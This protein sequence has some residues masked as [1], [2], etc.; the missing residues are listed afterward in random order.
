[1]YKKGISWLEHKDQIT[2]TICEGEAIEPITFKFS[3]GAVSASPVNIPPGLDWII[4]GDELLISGI[5]ISTDVDE[6][7]IKTFVVESIGNSCTPDLKLL[8]YLLSLMPK[9]IWNLQLKLEFR[10]FVK[11]LLL[12][13]SLILLQVEQLM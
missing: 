3:E 13:I 8:P 4:N 6:L 2:Q 7:T 10:M 1:M 5:P 12:K 11:G 9:L